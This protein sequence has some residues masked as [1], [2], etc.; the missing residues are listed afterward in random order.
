MLLLSLEQFFPFGSYW[1]ENLKSTMLEPKA[2]EALKWCNTIMS[3]KLSDHT[4]MH[5]IQGT[6]FENGLAAMSFAGSS[7]FVTFANK[8][9]LENI[10][11][12][13]L[14]TEKYMIGCTA[15]SV[16]NGTDHPEDAIKMWKEI[17]SKEGQLIIA[18]KIGFVPTRK[19]AKEEYIA[20]NPDFNDVFFEAA[21][22]AQAYGVTNKYFFEFV[23]NIR[24]LIDEVYYGQKEPE[25]AMVEFEKK[26]EAAKEQ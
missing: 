16:Y 13:T 25:E 22:K 14:P 3:E 4:I 23:N 15:W 19:S 1:D 11:V 18:E 6:L 17:T 26:Y 12:S 7:V 5:D 2:Q 10:A 21:S 20:M 9:G 24:P 8:L